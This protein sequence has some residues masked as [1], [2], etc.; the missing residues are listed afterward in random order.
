MR[1]APARLG[2][3]HRRFRRP[4]HG[5][6]AAR[7]CGHRA[8]RRGGGG[9]R[10]RHLVHGGPG[11]LPR[12]RARPGGLR[13]GARH[14]RRVVRLGLVARLCARGRPDADL[15]GGALS[16]G[17]RPAPGLV[18]LL[19]AR[20]LRHSR[21]G[22][23][24]SGADARF[25]ARRPGAQDGQVARQRC[26]AA[27]HRRGPRRRRSAPVGGVGGLYRRPADRPRHREGRRRILPPAA[28]YAALPPRQSRRFRR[29]GTGRACGDARTRALGVAPGSRSWKRLAGAPSRN[30]SITAS[31]ARSTPFARATCRR[32]ISMS[33]RIR[34]IA[35]LSARR[36]GARRGAFFTSCSTR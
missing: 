36:D 25:R 9:T 24:R 8:R 27:A 29:V 16:R 6:T 13:T 1:F 18:P 7:R 31:T 35:T 15:A 19:A 26:R 22:A 32:S 20:S 3:S 2:G 11:A 14:P 23:L 33:A 30:T 34:S 21:A 12:P 28:Q 17:L 4:A 10:R 5:R